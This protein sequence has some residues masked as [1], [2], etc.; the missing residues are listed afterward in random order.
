VKWILDIH[1]TNV[2]IPGCNN[3]WRNSHKRETMQIKY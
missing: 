3:D 1:R 2:L